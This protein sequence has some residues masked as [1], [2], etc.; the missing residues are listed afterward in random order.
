M[1]K[2]KTHDE[3]D[4]ATT[5]DVAA[6]ALVD[7]PSCSVDILRAAS[8]SRDESFVEHAKAARTSSKRTIAADE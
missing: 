7:Y 6:Q 3:Q 2:S 8:A 5:Q 4:R 1:A